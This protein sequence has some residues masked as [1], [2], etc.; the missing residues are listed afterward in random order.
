MDPFG[1][2]GKCPEC[3]GGEWG[4][5]S[6]YTL[7]G[8]FAVGGSY[9]VVSFSCLS[10]G[11]QCVGEV[12][13]RGVGPIASFTPGFTF[14]TGGKVVGADRREQLAGESFGYAATAGAVGGS[15]TFTVTSERFFGL[16]ITGEAGLGKS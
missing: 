6:T 4:T 8:Y 1:L 16:P 14:L 10:N 3:P 9:S 15:L 12:I 5:A 11:L 7:A 13:C 2:T